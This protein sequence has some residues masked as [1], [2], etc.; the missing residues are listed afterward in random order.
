MEKIVYV[1]LDER[2]C[3]YKFPEQIFKSTDYEIVS[4]ELNIMPYK[5]TA[6]D[7]SKL[8][9]FLLKE[10][11]E[12]YGLVISLDTL[13]YGG[14]VP[15]RIHYLN[16]ETIVSRMDLIDQIKQ[17]NP[18]ILIYGFQVIMRC[19]SGNGADEEP[20]YYKTEGRKIHLNGVYKHKE[21]L[22]II[23][24]EEKIRLE[25]LNV[26]QEYLNDFENRRKINLNFDLNT[27]DY[28]KNNLI[29]FLI[30]CQ[31]DAGEYGYPA[32]DQEVVTAKIKEEKLRMKVYAYSG[33]DEL[34][35]IMVARMV[36]KLLKKTPKFFIKYPS[37]T[38][39]TVIPI[40]EDRYLDNTIKYQII[41]AG[42]VVVSSYEE[43]DLI[44]VALMGATRMFPTVFHNQR[45]I[46]VLTNLIETFE[47]INYVLDKKPVIIADLF[48]LNAGSI[49]VLDF[50]KENGL[51][52]KLAA[53]A[54]WNTSSNT[55]G[56]CIAQG[57]RYWLQG[58]DDSHL[59]FLIKRYI[60]DI[61]YC[62]IVRTS[63]TKQLEKHGMNYFNVLE[64]KGL[65]ASL[66]EKE[67][68]DFITRHLCEL[69]NDFLIENV[70]LPWKRMFEVDFDIKIRK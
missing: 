49:E 53:Y 60:E 57:I 11:K 29:D 42:G 65:A 2:P 20:T 51:L 21:D 68:S 70:N 6:G 28:A 47:F 46:D 64:T 5:R 9:E 26:N 66:V 25:N 18:K 35:V 14:L 67:L 58:F 61:G 3:N 43:A 37:L 39:G 33:A 55:L 1:S 69:E 4:P 12:A 56:T 34:G 50:I 52:K 7:F 54:G 36:N 45:D 38:S 44:L 10:T 63:V 40:L 8:K 22:G 19:P 62:N 48:F 16:E 15:S 17:N 32:M 41:S 30:L 59:A 31:D 23:T 24:N 27:I 13:L